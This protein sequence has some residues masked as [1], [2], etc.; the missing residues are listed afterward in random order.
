MF[1]NTITKCVLF[2]SNMFSLKNVKKGFRE[3]YKSKKI[4]KKKDPSWISIS[5]RAG[6]S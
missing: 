1:G 4:T 3:T 5:T 6:A 2:T